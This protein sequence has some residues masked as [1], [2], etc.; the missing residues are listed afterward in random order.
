MGTTRLGVA[1]LLAVA[2]IALGWDSSVLTRLSLAG[3]NRLEQSL[4]DA[5]KPGGAAPGNANSMAMTNPT[6]YDQ[7]NDGRSCH[8]D[9]RASS[10]ED[11]ADRG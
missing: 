10:P 6:R 3:T 7:F 9:V 8:D 2:A 11:P 5:I 1:V 4:I